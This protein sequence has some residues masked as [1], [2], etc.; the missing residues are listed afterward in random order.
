[1]TIC[2]QNCARTQEIQFVLDQTQ[3]NSR[4]SKEDQFAILLS[5]YRTQS[6]SSKP[7]TLKNSQSHQQFKKLKVKRPI[8]R[9]FITFLRWSWVFLASYDGRQEWGKEQ[10]AQISPHSVSL[11]HNLPTT[12]ETNK[13]NRKNKDFTRINKLIKGHLRRYQ[14]EELKMGTTRNSS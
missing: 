5:Q 10:L 12:M 4:N 14:T 1:M 7:N 3:P 9:T 2:I 8:W 6:R 11:E 13:Q